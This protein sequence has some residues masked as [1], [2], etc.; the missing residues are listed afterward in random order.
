[1]SCWPTASSRVIASYISSNNNK[2]LLWS[3]TH[4]KMTA[5]VSLYGHPASDKAIYVNVPS[6]VAPRGR[7]GT[8]QQPPPSALLPTGGNRV[9]PSRFP[10]S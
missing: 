10:V 7:V 2:V 5:H 4:L 1:M 6:A 8:A 9:S 3:I